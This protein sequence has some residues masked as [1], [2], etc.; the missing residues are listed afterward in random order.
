MEVIQLLDSLCPSL[1]PLEQK[2]APPPEERPQEMGNGQNDVAVGDGSEKLAAEPF[3][4]EQ[5]FFLLTGRAKGATPTRE[6]H[7]K[8]HAAGI[9][10]SAGEAVLDQS[11]GQKPPEDSLDDGSKGTVSPSE[12]FG[13]NAEELVQMILDQPE[14]RGVSSPPGLVDARADR[15]RRA[16]AQTPGQGR[17]RRRSLLQ[18]EEI[19][20]DSVPVR[21]R[22]LRD[23]A[24]SCFD[25]RF[26]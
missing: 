2:F 8:T 12:P 25:A 24:S 20:S 6:R 18:V 14:Q 21:A 10:I 15:H 3:G 7:D 9:A 1:D 11:A 13:V 5:L 16:G 19:T 22:A 4:P 23:A 17:A 26:R